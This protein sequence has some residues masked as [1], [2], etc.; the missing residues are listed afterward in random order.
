MNQQLCN[1]SAIHVILS[2]VIQIKCLFYTEDLILIYG[3]DF[4]DFWTNVYFSLVHNIHQIPWCKLA[5]I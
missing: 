3:K 2:L 1:L 4:S 5:V